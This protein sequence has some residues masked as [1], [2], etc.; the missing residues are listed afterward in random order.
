MSIP[1]GWYVTLFYSELSDNT[2]IYLDLIISV[3]MT[4]F[5]FFYK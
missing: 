4:I 1:T 5:L 3:L 2:S